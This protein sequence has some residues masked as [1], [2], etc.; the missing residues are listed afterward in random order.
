MI[1]GN[2]LRIGQGVD[3]GAPPRI[4]NGGGV[5]TEETKT[6]WIHDTREEQIKM[7]TKKST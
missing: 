3:R 4:P 6:G 1:D 7:A 2:A 5:C